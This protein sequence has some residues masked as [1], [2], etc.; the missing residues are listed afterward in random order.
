MD[1]MWERRLKLYGHLKQMEKRNIFNYVDKLKN[2]EGRTK[3]VKKYA[4]KK[5]SQKK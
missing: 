3:A 2:S 4:N 1:K 5:V